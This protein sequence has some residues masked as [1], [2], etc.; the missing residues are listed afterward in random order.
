MTRSVAAAAVRDPCLSAVRALLARRRV[1]FE[2]KS[3][4]TTAAAPP[5]AE[6][7]RLELLARPRILVTGHSMGGALA[8]LCALE[9]RVAAA[10]DS[11]FGSQFG[12]MHL[13]TFGAPGVGNEAF[14]RHAET[15]IPSKRRDERYEFYA[16][17]ALDAPGAHK[18]RGVL[19][20][21]LE[22]EDQ[23]RRR[24]YIRGEAR[25]RL[26]GCH[27]QSDE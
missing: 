12:P 14:V 5:S 4:A 23:R 20:P 16:R 27:S 3:A 8:L 15:Y 11:A 21:V 26:G 22:V 18:P 19:A 24:A 9:L 10:T 1:Q 2:A 13:Y 25:P 7:E 17:R 6:R